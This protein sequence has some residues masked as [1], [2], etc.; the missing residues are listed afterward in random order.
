[1]HTVTPLALKVD[2]SQHLSVTVCLLSS[3]GKRNR[4][5][6]EEKGKRREIGNKKRGR[7]GKRCEEVN[8]GEKGSVSWKKDK[9][10]REGGESE[11]GDGW[12]GRGLYERENDG[13]KGRKRREREGRNGGINEEANKEKINPTKGNKE[14][15]EIEWI[16]RRIWAKKNDEKQGK[17]RATRGGMALRGVPCTDWRPDEATSLLGRAAHGLAEPTRRVSLMLGSFGGV[18]WGCLVCYTVDA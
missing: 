15:E 12:R 8:E 1:M 9:W 14:W 13:K 16:W 17:A 10:E 18:L 5:R 2:A 4:R 11:F 3:T 6:G 7:W